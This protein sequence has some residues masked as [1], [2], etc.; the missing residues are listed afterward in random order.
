VKEGKNTQML[1]DVGN[2]LPLQDCR[3]REAMVLPERTL[4]PGW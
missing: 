2:H 4:N 1:I 3:E